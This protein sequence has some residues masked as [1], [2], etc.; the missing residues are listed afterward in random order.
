MDE[1][2]LARPVVYK[3]KIPLGNRKG[4]NMVLCDD[5]GEAY[6]K[7]LAFKSRERWGELKEV[8]IQTFY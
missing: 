5:M 8:K 2:S 1:K 7:L 6:C 3:G 4:S